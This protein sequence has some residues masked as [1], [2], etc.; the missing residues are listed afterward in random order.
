MGMTNRA[1][2]VSIVCGCV[3]VFCGISLVML[4]ATPPVDVFGLVLGALMA[5]AGIA[6]AVLAVVRRSR[7]KA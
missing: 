1:L 2:I 3:L 7:A 5:A 6:M 4:H